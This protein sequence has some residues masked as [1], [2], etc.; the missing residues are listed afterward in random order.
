MFY[1]CKI[2]SDRFLNKETPPITDEPTL[3]LKK[4]IENRPDKAVIDKLM[5]NL[6]KLVFMDYRFLLE[7]Q[8]VPTLFYEYIIKFYSGGEEFESYLDYLHNIVGACEHPYRTNDLNFR[9]RMI[10]HHKQIKC[11][12]DTL[13]T[14][15]FSGD[16]IK[17]PHQA[18]SILKTL[19]KPNGAAYTLVQDSLY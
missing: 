1:R 8:P 5:G 7:K 17:D 3:E 12:I 2:V 4:Q 19:A 9:V 10:A 14:R 18:L 16:N 13:V 11:F 6:K 15:V